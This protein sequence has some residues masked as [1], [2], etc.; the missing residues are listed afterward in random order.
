[1]KNVILLEMGDKNDEIKIF[2][3]LKKNKDVRE[4]KLFKFSAGF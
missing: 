1:M 2:L 3:A 4:C